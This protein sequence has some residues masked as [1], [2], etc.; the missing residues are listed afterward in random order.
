MIAKPDYKYDLYVFNTNKM[1]FLGA[2]YLTFWSGIP[3]RLLSCLARPE[4][5]EYPF[6]DRILVQNTHFM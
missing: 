5:P 2:L 6:P 4:R 3:E 1:S